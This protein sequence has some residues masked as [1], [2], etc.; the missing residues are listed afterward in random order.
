MVVWSRL[1]FDLQPYLGTRSSEGASL[2]AFYHRELAEVATKRYLEGNR[3]ARHATLASMFRTMAD[4][5]GDGSW[6]GRARALSE[7]PYHLTG[8]RE[9]QA[10]YEALSDFTFLEE[11]AARVGVIE[12]PESAGGTLYT[13]VYALLE[14]YETAL[15]AFPAE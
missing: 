3:A 2:L 10:V 4:P 8:A 12:R 15:A 13:G 1:F 11:K 6:S 14:D 7:L 5:A 9:W